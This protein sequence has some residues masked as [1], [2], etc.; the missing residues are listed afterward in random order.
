MPRAFRIALLVVAAGLGVYLSIFPLAE[1][2]T[3]VVVLRTRD[4]AGDSHE[5]RVTIIDIE[6][7][8]WIRGRPRRGWLQRLRADPRAELWRNGAWHP[9]SA[10]ISED[11]EHAD[12][13][14]RV[15]IERY[16][17]LYRFMDLIAR[18]STHEVPV[19]L[20]A[21]SEEAPTPTARGAQRERTP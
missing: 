13:F 12:A 16:G 5:T 11:P 4:A 21:R 19:R 15:M 3:E 9:V 20:V 14:E 10:E 7:E 18:M 2:F 17:A 1:L 6:D 8:A